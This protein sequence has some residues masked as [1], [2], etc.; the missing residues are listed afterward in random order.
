MTTLLFD[1]R[2]HELEGAEQ[3]G[4]GLWIR[5][6]ELEAATGWELRP[7]GLCQGDVCIPV[8]SGAQWSD[9][10][11][12]SVTAFA[13]HLRRPVLHDAAHDVWSVGPEPGGSRLA[14][15]VAPDFTLPDFEGRLH[16]LAEY[17]GKKVLLMTWASW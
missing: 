8:P 16:S 3:R 17:R 5:R 6:S 10:D 2:V 15:G 12:V 4:A 11:R 14:S 1:G 9:A 13:R 7:E